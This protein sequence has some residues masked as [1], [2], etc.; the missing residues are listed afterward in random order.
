MDGFAKSEPAL[1][2][3][4]CVGRGIALYLFGRARAANDG[5]KGVKSEEKTDF[6]RIL[7][8]S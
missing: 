3:A 1:S 2:G 5:K 8:V 4:C 7:M 6:T